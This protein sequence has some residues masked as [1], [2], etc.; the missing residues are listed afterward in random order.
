MVL[1]YRQDTLAKQTFSTLVSHMDR[2]EDVSGISHH[3]V[4]PV[5]MSDAA[6]MYESLPEEI[7]KQM[8]ISGGCRKTDATSGDFDIVVCGGENKGLVYALARKYLANANK[9]ITVL[10]VDFSSN[11]FGD[12][13]SDDIS[14]DLTTAQI[15]GKSVKWVSVSDGAA[16]DMAR[17]LIREEGLM[18]GPM[19][20]AVMAA[21]ISAIDH[22]GLLI[23]L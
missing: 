3:R 16:Y 1:S 11:S 21:A 5:P 23:N 12:K 19:S 17:R 2:F 4:I 6:S 15:N 14:R 13:A 7:S 9:N 8:Q 20:G 18:V 10:G 22:L